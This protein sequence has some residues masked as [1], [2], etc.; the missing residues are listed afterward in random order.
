MSDTF[1]VLWPDGH[2]SPEVSLDTISQW[3]REG[4]IKETALVYGAAV[5]R[6]LPLSEA[7]PAIVRGT[8]LGSGARPGVAPAE[9][10]APPVPVATEPPLR[11]SQPEPS[12][13]GTTIEEGE[14][15][16]GR[17]D[18][19]R[20]GGEKK[21][22]PKPPRLGLFRIHGEDRGGGQQAEI[23]MSAM[24]HKDALKSAEFLG[25]SVD[26]VED[27]S[28]GGQE[29]R[30]GPDRGGNTDLAPLPGGGT[31]TK[32][33]REAEAVG[34]VGRGVPI[35]AIKP[36]PSSAY[37]LALLSGSL[38]VLVISMLCLLL[39]RLAFVSA[40]ATKH[41]GLVEL[42]PMVVTWGAEFGFGWLF[43]HRWPLTGWKWGL[44]LGGPI[45]VLLVGNTLKDGLAQGSAAF[46]LG[47]LLGR[48]AVPAGFILLA[49]LGA[50][51][52]IRQRR[53]ALR[54]MAFPETTETS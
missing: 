20:G 36:A 2:E 10:T 25:F 26:W 45:S 17:P 47:D 22:E 46:A 50:L 3:L 8:P 5:K 44:W 52:G 14:S 53:M 1:K 38:G 34:A 24:S 28:E 39:G 33:D 49:S 30:Q 7:L 27:C 29:G 19:Y 51:L 37:G 21:E 15:Y 6:W 48:L 43:G 18:E 54:R 32:L 4:S 31:T 12:E 11:A 40:G 41:G 13:V 16:P 35:Q 9:R 42:Y 23:M